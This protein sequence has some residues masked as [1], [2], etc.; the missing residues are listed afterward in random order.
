MIWEQVCKKIIV[1]G[2]QIWRKCMLIKVRVHV[3][4]LPSSVLC[5]A[6]SY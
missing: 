6:F 4:F 3:L 1:E 5:F 2:K